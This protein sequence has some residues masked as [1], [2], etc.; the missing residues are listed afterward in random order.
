M[1][2]PNAVDTK[3]HTGA[4]SM[5]VDKQEYNIYR[6]SSIRSRELYSRIFTNK[7]QEVAVVRLIIELFPKKN[8]ST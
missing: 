6:K 2:Q 5:D 8:P 1:T 4:G 7:T 3:H